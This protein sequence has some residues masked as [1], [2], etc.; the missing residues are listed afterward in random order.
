[1]E[2]MEH[3]DA[4]RLQAVE[5]YILGEL[6]PSLRDEFEVHYFDCMDCSLNLRSG[7]AFA[8]ASRQFFAES[9]V[10][11]AEIVAAKPGWFS[12]LKP[13]VAAPVMAALLLIIGYQYAVS[14]PRSNPAVGTWYSLVESNVKGPAGQ[15]LI[16]PQGKPFSVFF[17]ITATPKS[18]DSVF[19]VELVEPAG[20]TVSS[21]EVS[22]Q[23]AQKSVLYNVPAATREGE[24]NLVISEKTAGA[25]TPA[26]KVS[27]TVAFSR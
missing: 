14:T 5:K 1:M 20:K 23:A 9:F 10:R 2:N 18:S 12:W 25:K 4:V 24:Y 7:V 17:D 15:T 6:A 16:V 27:F 21:A 11:Q 13:I 8:A 3:T 22:A 19:L 26:G